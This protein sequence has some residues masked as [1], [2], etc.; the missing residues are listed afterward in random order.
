MSGFIHDDFLLSTDISQRLYHEYAAEMPIIDY[1]NHLNPEQLAKN[2]QFN[3]L[4]EVWLAGDHYKW[5][6]MRANGIDEEFI[7]GAS[8]PFQ[9]FMKW[10]ETVPFTVGNPLYHWTHMELLRYFGVD[11]LLDGNNAAQIFNHCNEFLQ[12]DDFKARNLVINKNVKV[13][14]TTDDPADALNF[15]QTLKE[16]EH[17]ILVIPTFRPDKMLIVQ[18]PGYRDYILKLSETCNHQISSF[19]DLIEVAGKRI[20]DGGRRIG[21][22][23]HIP[24]L[25]RSH[26]WHA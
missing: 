22:K 2:H 13:L 16:I 9:K 7:T 10:A 23:Q 4:T 25:H 18:Q 3:D 6:A 11:Q 20:D 24:R 15:H 12:Q 14:C 26:T 5:R 19:K 17:S 21:T 8:D 1:H